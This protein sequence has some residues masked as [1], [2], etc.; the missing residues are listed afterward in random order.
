[1]VGVQANLDR[2]AKQSAVDRIGIALHMQRAAAIHSYMNALAYVNSLCWQRPQHRQLLGQPLLPAAVQLPKHLPHERRVVRPVRKIPAAAQQQRLV[3]R[4]LALPMTL[5]RIAVLVRL[6]R[7]DRLALQAV[8]LQ[9]LAVALLEDGPL[10]P[11]RHGGGQRIGA[12][13]LGHAAQ[14]GQRVLQSLAQA[15]EALAET[16][17]ARLPV[18][19]G[20][21][22]VE[23]QVRKRLAADGDVQAGTVREVRRRQ[24]AGP[25]DLGEK[26]LLG[27][28]VQRAPLLDVPLQGAQLIV[29]EPAGILSLQPGEQRLGFQAG[30]DGELLLNARPDVGERIGARS[31]GMCHL[32]LAG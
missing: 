19:V 26:D 8:V 13:Y 9:Q 25:M 11:G 4:P 15:L 29:H 7:V 23:E 2:L 30:V 5:L 18:R 16:D 27:R 3:Q 20:E 22:E 17:R 10:F 12:M 14:L 1:V 6:G 28:A 24:P 31:P 21:H 32:H